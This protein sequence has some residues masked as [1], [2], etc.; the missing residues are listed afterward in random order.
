MEAKI[1]KIDDVLDL[2]PRGALPLD[3]KTYITDTVKSGAVE[4]DNHIIDQ[5]LIDVFKIDQLCELKAYPFALVGD[6]IILFCGQ[7]LTKPQKDL[8]TPEGFELICLTYDQSKIIRALNRQFP[9][10]FLD[11][12]KFETPFLYS[13][14]SIDIGKTLLIAMC[15]L[16]IIT[17]TLVQIGVNLLPIILSIAVFFSFLNS[18]LRFLAMGISQK[19]KPENLP[20]LLPNKLPKVSVI[21]A[22]YK[23]HK[24]IPTLLENLRRIHYPQSLLEIKFLL[25]D[26]DA[27]TLSKLKSEKLPENFEVIVIPKDHVKTKPKALNYALH[28]CTGE[29]IGIY[30]AEDNPAPNQIYDVACAFDKFGKDTACIQ[31]QLDFFNQSENWFSRC[32]TI[33]YRLWFAA[34]L[35]LVQRL[36]FAVP[37]GGTSVFIK[38]SVLEKLGAWDAFNVTEDADLGIRIKRAGYKTGVIR[39]K[40]LEE[41]NTRAV[42]WIRQRSRWLKGYMVTWLVHMRSPK[43]LY[44]ELGASGFLG[45]QIMFLGAVINT[46]AYPVYALLWLNLFDIDVI[47]LGAMSTEWK[48]VLYST[49]FFSQLANLGLAMRA[50]ASHKHTRWLA[51]WYFTMPLYWP[52]AC[53]AGYKALIELIFVPFYWDKTEHGVTKHSADDIWHNRL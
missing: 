12:A 8:L 11:H 47:G 45:I 34:L 26:D 52:L 25:E 30:D 16:A 9:Q 17:L 24:I 28:F 5:K 42:S 44:R 39:S 18:G 6:Q 32:F 51:K 19:V 50:L 27:L 41:A 3:F 48:F 14:R 37:L 33:E 10:Y 23:E 31:C 4:I 35:P 13:V 40:T 46:L 38:R 1:I 53:I 49:L 22:L 2:K 36:N 7:Y 29:I 20:N 21:V 15:V 43:T